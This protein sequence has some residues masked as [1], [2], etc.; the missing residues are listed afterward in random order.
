MYWNNSSPTTSLKQETSRSVCGE[1]VCGRNSRKP[2][3]SQTPPNA[4]IPPNP[5]GHP[6]LRPKVPCMKEE[7][8]RFLA[9]LESDD[10][11]QVEGAVKSLLAMEDHERAIGQGSVGRTAHKTEGSSQDLSLLV[12]LYAEQAL[13]EGDLAPTLL[14]MIP[15]QKQLFSSIS[16]EGIE[17]NWKRR[18]ATIRASSPLGT[19][20]DARPA[21]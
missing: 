3:L 13:K 14:K 20:H 2:S 21:P 4:K 18:W 7:R 16:S 9:S 1:N 11:R 17:G 15:I 5:K 8:A 12:G 19:S 6:P 10:P